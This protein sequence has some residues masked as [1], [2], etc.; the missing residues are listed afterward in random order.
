MAFIPYGRQSISEEDIRAVIEVL[1][2]DFLT[3]G[4]AVPAFE[5]AV[6]T[7]CGAAH[8][9]AANSATSALHLACLALGVGDGDLV[10][11]SPITFVASANCV[12]Y[13]GAAIDFVDIDPAT[14]NMSAAALAEK[15]E[16]AVKAGGKLPKAVIPVHMCGQSCDMAAIHGL[17]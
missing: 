14:L 15:L 2:S 6:R 16:R 13:C 11:T 7:H 5:T 12:L 3:Q 8:A 4:P 1:R 10:W 17:A 9:V